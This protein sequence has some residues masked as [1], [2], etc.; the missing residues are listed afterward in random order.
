MKKKKIVSAILLAVVLAA[1]WFLN[2]DADK[3]DIPGISEDGYYYSKDEV[4][5][6]IDSFGHL[7]G[8]YITKEEARSLGWDG[9]PLDPFAP[10]MAIGGDSFSNR[11]GL[12]PKGKKYR[13]CD[14]DTH[15]KGRG[16]KRIIYSSDGCIYYT[17]DHYE[18]FELLYGEEE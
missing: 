8:N 16:E 13:E 9:G 6:Y 1:L 10:D 11:E 7:P 14:I 15:K 5:L 2:T 12:L 4:A 3:P 17:D 18:S